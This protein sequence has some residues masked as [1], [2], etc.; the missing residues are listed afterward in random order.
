MDNLSIRVIQAKDNDARKGDQ[1]MQKYSKKR[2]YH[3]TFLKKE[4]ETYYEQHA[5]T[6]AN[7]YIKIEKLPT[8]SEKPPLQSRHIYTI[9]SINYMH[10]RNTHPICYLPTYLSC[11]FQALAGWLTSNS[12]DFRFTLTFFTSIPFCPWCALTFSTILCNISFGTRCTHQ[13]FNH[14]NTSPRQITILWA[15]VETFV[16]SKKSNIT[17][18]VHCMNHTTLHDFIT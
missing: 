13:F 9:S 2:V 8:A 17:Y 12:I 4:K 15:F 3:L 1:M 11:I 16:V 10:F 18:I 5:N 6:V 14:K 7:I